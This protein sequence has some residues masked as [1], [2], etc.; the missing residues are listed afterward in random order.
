MA[1]SALPTA[2]ATN[3]GTGS[4]AGGCAGRGRLGRYAGRLGAV[5]ALALLL[6]SSAGTG[7]ERLADVALVTVPPMPRPGY[8]EPTVDPAFATPFVRVSDPGRVLL[9]GVVC[10]PSHC[11]HRYASTQ[12]W[13]A[14]QTLLILDK[15]CRGLCF[16]DGRNYRP[17]F[18]R[19]P[20]ASCEWHPAEPDQMICV[21][22]TEIFRWS[23]RSDTRT[24]VFAPRDYGAL[25]FGPKGN[26]TADGDRLVLRATDRAG[27][28]VAFAYDLASGTKHPD[29]PLGRL[30]GE[31]SY[32]TISPTG[33]YVFCFQR[34]PEGGHAA[35][36]LSLDGE[37]VQHWAENHRP[38][39]GDMTVDADG[40]DVYVGI[41]KADPDKYRVIKRRLSDGAV[42]VLTPRGPAQHA[43][44]RSSGR[45]G[46]VFLTYGRT[47]GRAGRSGRLR[48]YGE[49]VAL[50]VDGSG[51]VRRIVHTRT[52]GDG[53]L[54][55]AHASPS[56]DGSQVIWASNWGDET[57]PVA[58]YVARLSWP[59]EDG[60]ERPARRDRRSL[61]LGEPRTSR[62]P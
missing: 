62:D 32:C 51:E 25:S 60:P 36:V 17:L 52:A 13:N 44:L 47:A 41:S 53:Y 45:P 20:G 1:P 34:M 8:L 6:G 4:A 57:G 3:R 27:V 18:Q 46:W 28:R 7:P 56:P 21:S 38:G 39:H 33:L 19:D 61:A 37:Q 59:G 42:T 2:P 10:A 40:H 49:I 43:S 54:A 12:A 55:E 31:N 23:V 29:I 26:L 30:E 11:R 48:L 14:D 24:T 15:G 16:L 22:E 9:P 50:R 5:A 58:S 35:Y